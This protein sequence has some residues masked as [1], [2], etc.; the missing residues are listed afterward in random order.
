MGKVFTPALHVVVFLWLVTVLPGCDFSIDAP[1]LPFSE[2]QVET[3]VALGDG[4]MSGFTNSTRSHRT[5]RAETGLYETGQAYSIPR[6][7]AG[8]YNAL[9]EIH[10]YEPI[11]FRQPIATG[12]GSGRLIAEDI[13]APACDFLPTYAITQREPAELSWTDFVAPPIHNFALPHLRVSQLDLPLST[14][15]GWRV[16][17]DSTHSYQEL[18]RQNE[19]DIFLLWLGTNDLLEYALAG[20]NEGGYPLTDPAVFAQQLEQYLKALVENGKQGLVATLPDVSLFPYFQTVPRSYVPPQSCNAIP[21]RVFVEC[22]NDSL[23]EVREA[24]EEDLFLL[25]AQSLI[26][27][28]GGFGLS[29][30]QALEHD[31]IL[32]R[33]ELARLRMHLAA[34][35]EAIETIVGN[36]NTETSVPRIGIVQL[37]DVFAQLQKGRFETGVFLD[38]RHLTG[39]VF[40]LDGLYLSPRG[41]ALIANQFIRELNRLQGFTATLPLL[42]L[43]EYSGVLFP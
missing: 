11:L 22:W 8:Q 42:N 43:R 21:K 39:G 26:G 15:F 34:Y 7:V 31:W 16:F 10:G 25:H 23:L 1:V 41:N 20:G 18:T 30:D 33:E 17:G 40:N 6:L 32:D 37:D 12:R 2:L 13:A 27:A 38:N 4:Y 35:N 9:R 19:A 28:N 5:I 14:S 36:L 3:L 29:T 24:R